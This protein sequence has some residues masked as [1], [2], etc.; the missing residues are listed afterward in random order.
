ML[1]HS[2]SNALSDDYKKRFGTEIYL[3]NTD[4]E[5][6]SPL[7]S[8]VLYSF[9]QSKYLSKKELTAKTGYI[10]KKLTTLM[11]DGSKNSLKGYLVGSSKKDIDDNFKKGIYKIIQGRM[12]HDNSECI[13]SKSLVDE[14]QLKVGDSITLEN[15]NGKELATITLKISGIYADMSMQGYKNVTDT[16]LSHPYNRIFTT[17]ETVWNSKLFQNTGNLEVRMFLKEPSLLASFKKELKTKGL[18]SSYIVTIDETG[19]QRIMGPIKSIA[20]IS[21]NMIVGILLLGSCILVLLSLLS[22]RERRYEVGVLR[23]MGMKKIYI[24]SGLLLE[25]W[26]ITSICLCLGLAVSQPFSQLLADILMSSSI[27]DV[28][29]AGINSIVPRLNGKTLVQICAISLLIASIASFSG[30]VSI[31]RFEPIKILNDRKS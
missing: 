22:I 20:K 4:K 11:D 18:P 15:N 3:Q 2:M 17:W 16:S 26:I 23:S 5:R 10:P 13:V 7:S 1:L 31:V 29:S 9:A 30:I 8:K 6:K 24:I 25:I 27:E 19:Y 14:N 21:K 12:Y 28:K